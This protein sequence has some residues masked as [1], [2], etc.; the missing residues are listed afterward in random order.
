MKVFPV[1]WPIDQQVPPL[2]AAVKAFPGLGSHGTG[3]P[4]WWPDSMKVYPGISNDAWAPGEHSVVR[5]DAAMKVHAAV[6]DSPASKARPLGAAAQLARILV[7]FVYDPDR[8]FP[9]L[10]AAEG[11]ER[12][13]LDMMLDSGAFTVWTQDATIDLDA[14]IEWARAYHDD[15]P[16]SRIVNL[17]VLPGLPGREPSLEQRETAA[18]ESMANADKMREAGL[19]NLVEVFHW[20]ESWDVLRE[21][22]ERRRPG[23]IIGIGG[24]AG[25][26][27]RNEKGEFLGEVFGLVKQLS[28]DWT[29]TIPLHGFGVAPN[30][31]LARAFPWYSVDAS[32]WLSPARFGQAVGRGGKRLGRDSRTNMAEVSAIYLERVLKEWKSLELTYSRMWH[33][34]GIRFVDDLEG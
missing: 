19:E 18:R 11:V 6:G 8:R 1:A 33:E 5:R 2:A 31:P 34:R 22:I 16:N 20:H 12:E 26:G 32:S 7:S 4:D 15:V 28:K 17:D 14:Y 21:I 25:P 3:W 29:Q 9:D 27:G 24:V 30:S 23:E 13:Q 10:M